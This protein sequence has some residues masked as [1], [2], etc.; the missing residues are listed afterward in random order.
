MTDIYITEKPSKGLPQ[1]ILIYLI[2]DENK[3]QVGRLTCD[4]DYADRYTKQKNLTELSWLDYLKHSL[5]DD[6]VAI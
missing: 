4:K 5:G 3:D 1:G 2:L 6:L